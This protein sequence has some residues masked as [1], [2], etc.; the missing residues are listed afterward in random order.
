MLL[1]VAGGDETVAGV[2]AVAA[3]EDEVRG[4]RENGHR[5]DDL[6]GQLAAGVFHEQKRGDAELLGGEAV[7]LAAFLNAEDRRPDHEEASWP[8]F[9]RTSRRRSRRRAR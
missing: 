7:D 8:G 1:E 2:V 9:W 3:E 4:A 5:F 6:G